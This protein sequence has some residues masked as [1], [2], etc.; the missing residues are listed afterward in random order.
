VGF[1][2][3]RTLAGIRD[4]RARER[5]QEELKAGHSPDMVKARYGPAA[6]PKNKLDALRAE[7]ERLQKSIESMRKRLKEIERRLSELDQEE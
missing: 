7:R 3:M 4:D 2:N 6:A 1:E 5:A